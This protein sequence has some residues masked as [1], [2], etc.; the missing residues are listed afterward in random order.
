MMAPGTS[1]CTET[2]RAKINLAL[3]VTGKR[4]DGYHNLD[5]LVAFAAVGDL[6]KAACAEDLSL[7]IHG[8]G[9]KTL[10][11]EP[12]N[13][14]LTAARALSSHADASGL[15]RTCAGAGFVL[16]KHLPVSAGIGGG[17]ADAAASLRAMN[18]L[19][20]L[21]LPQLQLEQL[22]L[23]LGA[24]V[25]VCVGSQSCRMSGMGEKLEPLAEG[26]LPC[27]D[28]VLVNPGVPVATPKVFQTLKNITQSALPP[29]PAKNNL[30]SW[31]N[32]LDGTRNDLFEP[33]CKLCPS[34]G[35][36]ISELDHV[37]AKF[38]RMSGSGATCFG[39][40]DT[41]TAAENAANT[42][43]KNHPGWWVCATH[44]V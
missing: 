13:S 11:S 30:E 3:H 20:D 24:D 31:L 22:G 16:Q 38:S 44:T 26:H 40:F 27:L 7:S 29:F 2:A 21:Q 12:T 18:T 41:Q 36:V 23:E 14:V 37:G 25:A 10:Q 33:A 35:F 15:N 5:S 43:Q 8:A 6:L 9:A 34:I 39:I 19:W 1:V 28:L 4:A 42:L 32:W 17:S